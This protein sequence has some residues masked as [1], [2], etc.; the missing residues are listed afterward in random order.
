MTF[1]EIIECAKTGNDS[2]MDV[3]EKRA[4]LGLRFIIEDFKKGN[5]TT[6][7]VKLMESV[8]REEYNEAVRA[9]DEAFA[10]VKRAQDALTNS[11]STIRGILSSVNSG[12]RDYKRMFLEALR[13]YSEIT[14]ECV[15][16]KV[17]TKKIMEE[18][19]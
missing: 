10:C 4:Y 19:K 13:A 3:I 15:T 8:I 16:E 5:R 14:G 11:N 17:I 2:E 12:D 9:H 6:E 7:Q 18:D 1:D